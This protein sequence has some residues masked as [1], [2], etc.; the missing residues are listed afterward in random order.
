MESVI[1]IA[2]AVEDEQSEKKDRRREAENNWSEVGPS[3]KKSKLY[4]DEL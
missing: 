4:K 2:K 3:A 1:K